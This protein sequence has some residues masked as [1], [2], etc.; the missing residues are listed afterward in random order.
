MM[1]PEIKFPQFTVRQVIQGTLLVLLVAAAFYFFYRFHQVFLTMFLAIVIS[2]AIRPIVNFFNQ[3]GIPEPVTIFLIFLL[4]AVLIT[5]SLILLVPQ[6]AEQ[7][8]VLLASLPEAYENIREQLLGHPNFFVWRIASELPES[9]NL[10]PAPEPTPEEEDV[11][12]VIESVGNN[13]RLIGLGAR[14]IFFVVGTLV[15]AFYWTLDGKKNRSALLLL[16]KLQHRERAREIVDEIRVRLGAY[17]RGQAILALI[18]GCLS[19]VAYTLIG[20]PYAIPLAIVAG[21]MEVIPV[22]GPILGAVPALIVGYTVDPNKAL[23]VLLATIIIQ[24]MENN[25]LV[26]RVMKR[27]VGV[28]PLVTLLALTAFGSLFGI[29][30]A[31]VAIP[32]A[33]IIQLLLDQLVLSRAIS[34]DNEIIGRDQTSV[35]QYEVQE[36]TKD[37]RKTI[38]QKELKPDNQSD[39]IEDTIEAIAT[40]L[41]TALTLDLEIQEE[42]SN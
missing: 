29:L 3:R 19:L 26:P 41:L 34:N 6:I 21:L 2:T 30:G 8:D 23:F 20:L 4:I 22:I 12:D 17:V 1:V 39:H 36:L 35:L 28:N 40:D 16:V 24:Q 25:I 10:A 33:A 42:D 31:I 37:I 18:I 13:L 7:S 38:R 32:L 11:E 14:T 27:A 5:V 15:L 9:L